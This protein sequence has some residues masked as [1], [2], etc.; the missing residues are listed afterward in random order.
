MKASTRQKIRNFLTAAIPLL[1]A[2]LFVFV[3]YLNSKTGAKFVNHVVINEVCTNN[4]AIF[5]D[6]DND[7]CDYVEIYN[8]TKE[9]VDI[10]GWYLSEDSVVLAKE[11]LVGK[12]LEP[13]EYYLVYLNGKASFGQEYLASGP[14]R[15]ETQ[16]ECVRFSLSSKHREYVYLSDA[17]LNVVDQVEVPVMGEDMCYSRA[18]DGGSKWKVLTP[19]PLETNKS[20]REE[21]QPFPNA[22]PIPVDENAEEIEERYVVN[23]TMR[24]EDLYDYEKG[25]YTEGIAW[26]RYQAA[27]ADGETETGFIENDMVYH[28]NWKMG[29]KRQAFIQIYDYT[30]TLVE[31]KMVHVSC[32]GNTSIT[33]ET[34]SLN[35][36]CDEGDSFHLFSDTDYQESI[37][38][39]N[40]GSERFQTKYR[41]P[42]LQSRAKNLNLSVQDYIFAEVYL[43]GEFM[44][45]YEIMEKY[46][47]DY[48]RGHYGVEPESVAI[49][50]NPIGISQGYA[51]A[52]TYSDEADFVALKDYAR[53]HDLTDDS[54]YSYI[55]ERLDVESFL[56]Y[57]AVLAYLGNV[58]A[59]PNNNIFVWRSVNDDGNPYSDGKWRF[60]LQDLDST[61]G[62]DLSYDS[63]NPD[64]G[65]MKIV[66]D[67]SIDN[68]VTNLVA[69]EGD[70]A[71]AN[72]ATDP[73]FSGLMQR[74]EFKEAFREKLIDLSEHN[75][76]ADVMDKLIDENYDSIKNAWS[77]RADLDKDVLRGHRNDFQ[78]FFV[79]R[80]DYVL[81]YLDTHF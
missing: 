50:K 71:E 22:I 73:L 23:I 63:Y 4:N 45:P 6:A 55:A 46:S 37:L 21:A 70:G 69:W 34:K 68:F 81:E 58:D 62:A 72:L 51:V 24:A 53:A 33:D 40:G 41:D 7:G 30:G 66:V 64:E 8:P 3:I 31:E 65:R 2:G 19:T 60:M 80:L 67:N 16:G 38:L 43:N 20:G 26:D 35:V 1:I 14:L 5:I 42:L 77:E 48:F 10:R 75:Y 74:E 61:A 18:L 12:I 52:G 76:N 79:G 28:S 9:P 17:E 25:I 27:I 15:D 56:D 54:S 13:G 29:W 36:Y 47:P 39:R 59:Y 11:K 78:D 49:L 32:H 57:I 44:G